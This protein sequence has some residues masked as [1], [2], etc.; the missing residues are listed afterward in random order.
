MNPVC[1]NLRQM[2]SDG[3]NI[4]E[5]RAETP[6]CQH[7]NHLNNAGAALLSTPTLAAMTHQLQLEAQIGGYEAIAALAP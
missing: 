1:P 2:T 4:A 6:G 7:R 5:L 3:L